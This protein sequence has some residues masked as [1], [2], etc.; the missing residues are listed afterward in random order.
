[1]AYELHNG[2]ALPK[3]AASN[4]ARPTAANGAKG[5]M[6]VTFA[7]GSAE[8]AAHA[9]GSTGQE[10]AGF[11]ICNASR[12]QGLTVLAEGNVVKCV[13]VASIG[14]GANVGI[15]STN[16]AMGLVSAASGVV[17]HAAG[18][19]ETAAGAGEIFSVYVRPRQL[20]G[21]A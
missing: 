6:P 17:V 5:A 1:M 7:A 3:I 10:I 15:A 21:L 2:R 13:S 4:I 11:A 14:V 16:G 20:S 18:K 19:S 8:R 12:A 9:V